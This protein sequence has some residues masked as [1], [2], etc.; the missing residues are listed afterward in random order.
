M[1]RK[2]TPRSKPGQGTILKK[3]R[4]RRSKGRV[5]KDSFT[6]T[7]EVT[8][9]LVYDVNA[10]KLI[11]H[12]SFRLAEHHRDSI[13]AGRH[14]SGGKL[15]GLS[16]RTLDGT[17]DDRG[18]G[19]TFFNNTGDSARNWWLGPVIGGSVKARRLLKPV[20]MSDGPGRW[21][22]MINA[23]LRRGIDLQSIRG[24]AA[25]VI[26]KATDEYLDLAFGRTLGTPL[27]PDLTEGHLTAKKNQLKK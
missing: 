6:V 11:A 13:L 22:F 15:H 20:I 7:L 19:K 8:E 23:W 1:A 4:A 27:N 5:V 9:S 24:T 17:F 16:A 12:V 21:D 25:R 10:S 18:G 3:S 26:A 2:R 14:P